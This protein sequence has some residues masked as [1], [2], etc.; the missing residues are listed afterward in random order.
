M[1]D[2]I[3]HKISF[4]V[5]KYGSAIEQ[6]LDFVDVFTEETAT[7]DVGVRYIKI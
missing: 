7:A 5:Q 2:N 3:K 4:R 1:S 6:E